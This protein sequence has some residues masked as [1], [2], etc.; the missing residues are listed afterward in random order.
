M[1]EDVD[2]LVAPR[3]LDAPGMAL[4]IIGSEKRPCKKCGAAVWLS[5]DGQVYLATRP[6]VRLF[7]PACTAA[8]I[9]GDPD[10]TL[11]GTVPRAPR[12]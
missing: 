10:P 11:V 2:F 3:V 12:Q 5:P 1:N 9:K 8:E 6:L 7:C 4:V